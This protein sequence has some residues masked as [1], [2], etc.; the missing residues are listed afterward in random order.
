M[1]RRRVYP[2]GGRRLRCDT[3]R[4]SAGL[5]SDEVEFHDEGPE[6]V[7]AD[8]EWRWPD[9]LLGACRDKLGAKTSR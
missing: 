7:L 8:E 3:G 6:T 9:E 5:V 4:P 1:Q 2:G